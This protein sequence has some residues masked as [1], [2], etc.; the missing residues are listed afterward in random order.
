MFFIKKLMLNT[1]TY[2]KVLC[3]NLPE[4]DGHEDVNNGG[5]VLK[6]KIA[7][8]TYF[9]KSLVELADFVFAVPVQVKWK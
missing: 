8:V 3:P 1:D 9:C 4:A 5:E 2:I 7:A 6:L